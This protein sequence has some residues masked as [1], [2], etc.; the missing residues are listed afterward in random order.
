MILLLVGST[1]AG[2][3][4]KSWWSI[5]CHCRI[6]WLTWHNNGVSL[7]EDLSISVLRFDRSFFVP[8]F[9]AIM[10]KVKNRVILQMLIFF[11]FFLFLSFFFFFFGGG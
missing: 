11:L 10:R 1:E 3:Q 2:R 7:E 4:Q 9:Q 6:N 8:D 5:I